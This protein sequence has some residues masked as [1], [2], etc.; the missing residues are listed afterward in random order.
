MEPNLKALDQA[1]STVIDL[2]MRFGPKLLVA[3][4]IMVAG[5]FTA[6]WIGRAVDRATARFEFEPPARQLMFKLLPLIAGISVAGAGIALA[7]QGVLSNL[8][9]GLTI[10]LTRPFRVGEYISVAKEEGVVTEIRLAATTLTHADRSRVVIPNRRIVGEILHNCGQ[11]RQVQAQARVA[12]D[13]DLEQALT[14]IQGALQA[15]PRLLKDPAPV[16]SVAALDSG[17]TIGVLPWT[18]VADFAP[19]SSEV[20]RAIVEAFRE[21]GIAMATPRREVRL[22]EKAA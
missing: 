1:T 13:T 19:A 12:Y 7:M 14:A 10:V 18:R 20:N 5:Y 4:V 22:L 8:V 15:N 17:V 11:I 2:S 21:R 3:I 6:R 16:L 9:A